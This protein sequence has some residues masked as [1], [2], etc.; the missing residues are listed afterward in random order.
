MYTK[1]EVYGA[2]SFEEKLGEKLLERDNMQSHAVSHLGGCVYQDVV[3]GVD[4]FIENFRKPID[5][6]EA[7]IRRKITGAR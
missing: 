3:D 4:R 5:Q 2:N 6:S 1:Y 7:S